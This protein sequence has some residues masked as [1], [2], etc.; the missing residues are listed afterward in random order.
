MPADDRRTGESRTAPPDKP[1]PVCAPVISAYRIPG[2]QP[3]YLELAELYGDDLSDAVVLHELACFFERALLAGDT[4]EPVERCC[5][6][7]EAISARDPQAVSDHFLALL[8]PTG[9][10][11][12]RSWFGPRTNELALTESEDRNGPGS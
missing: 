8:S 7:L 11:R 5:E 1:G 12:A 6:C 3:S 10:E 4:D 9:L 2:F